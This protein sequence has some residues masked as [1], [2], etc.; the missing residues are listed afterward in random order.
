MHSAA[1]GRRFDPQV[2]AARYFCVTEAAASLQ[3]PIAVDVAEFGGELALHVR[4]RAQGDL[5]MAHMRDRVE[6]AGGTALHAAAG[7][8]ALLYVRLPAAA[9]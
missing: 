9:R 4:G 3:T 7:D 8:D 5:S 6:A 1:A 2:E